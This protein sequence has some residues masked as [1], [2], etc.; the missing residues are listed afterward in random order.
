MEK[1]CLL[2]VIS[3]FECSVRHNLHAPLGV[4]FAKQ[5][6][7]ARMEEGKWPMVCVCVCVLSVNAAFISHVFYGS[8]CCQ[9]LVAIQG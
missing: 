2:S 5:T 1:G 7:A 8:C 4:Q 3:R 6:G 9:L